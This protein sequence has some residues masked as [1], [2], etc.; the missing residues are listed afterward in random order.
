MDFTK[1]QKTWGIILFGTLIGFNETVIGSLNIQNKS[2]ILSAITLAF[3]SS[4][5]YYIPRI[6]TS[7]LILAIAVLFKLTDLGIQF[8]KPL[9]LILLGVGFEVFSSVFIGKKQFNFLRLI[10]TCVLTSTVM[11]T[12]FAVFE[13]YIVKNGYWIAAKFK[14]YIFIKG[15]LTALASTLLSV[16]GVYILKRINPERINLFKKHFLSQVVM[17]LLI[18]VLWIVGYSTS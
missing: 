10:L 15:P 14:D 8:C 17:G 3:F 6:G 13:T 1:K 2:I 16:L 12:T 18:A 11:F 5:R 9:M 4:A 7:L